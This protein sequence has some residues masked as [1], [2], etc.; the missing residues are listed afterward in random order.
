MTTGVTWFLG[1]HDEQVRAASRVLGQRRAGRGDRGAAAVGGRPH[2]TMGNQI[3][4]WGSGGLVDLQVP[5]FNRVA[6]GGMPADGPA[7]RTHD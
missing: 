2:A 6:I 1:P 5:P 3:Q 4:C 7:G